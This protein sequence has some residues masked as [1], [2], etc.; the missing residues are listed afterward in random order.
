MVEINLGNEIITVIIGIDGEAPPRDVQVSVEDLVNRQVN[1]EAELPIGRDSVTL[2]INENPTQDQRSIL[3][4]RVIHIEKF[5][6]DIGR[7]KLDQSMVNGAHNTVVDVLN[8]N[9]FNVTGTATVWK[10]NL[11]G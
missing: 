3:G 4:D 9:G 8:G 6:I 2:T 10:G 1:K 5:D 7:E 11:Q